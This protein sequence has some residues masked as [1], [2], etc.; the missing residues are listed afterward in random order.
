MTKKIVILT[1][2]MP[3]C[4]LCSG[5]RTI[6][7]DLPGN[8]PCDDIQF[9]PASP[10]PEFAS[11]L[12]GVKYLVLQQKP[13]IN[14]HVPVFE[15][16]VEYLK[17][18][19]FTS[20]QYLDENHKPPDHYC[21]EALVSLGFDYQIGVAFS[22]ITMSWVS[23]CS[24]YVW[25]FSSDKRVSDE[26]GSDPKYGFGVLFREMYGFMKPNFDSRYTL[27]LPK[28]QTCWTEEKFRS[29]VQRTGC[30]KIEGIYENSIGTAVEAKY[31]V[32]IRNIHGTYYVVYL[33]GAN[34]YGD[35]SEGEIKGTLESTATPYFYK[36]KW[37]M[38]N[39]AENPNEYISFDGGIMK[40]ITEKDKLLYIK[41]FPSAGDNGN[42]PSTAAA[43]SGSGFAI[44]SNGYIATNCHV[45]NGSTSIRVRGV[46]GDFTRAYR[47]RVIMEDQKNDLSIIKIDDPRFA[48]FG[49]IPYIISGKSS[50]V[51]SA[52]FCLGYPLR[53]TMGDEV[54]LT[55]GIISSRTGFRGDITAYQISAPVQPGNSGGPLFDERGN[56]V[57]II[58]AKHI[59]AE[60]VTYAIKSSYLL[61]LID[62]LPQGP[63][64]SAISIVN[65][66]LLPEQVKIVKKF[67]YIIEVNE[68]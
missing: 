68:E 13:S 38:S 17:A 2:L 7:P 5:Q 11:F 14:G 35:W 16:L 47:A 54:K 44:A 24:G 19:G 10:K 8:A 53:A 31:R 23:P 9:I 15:A 58:N 37:L 61:S 1:L 62:D 50:E 59:D 63:K 49:T 4:F 56:L 3:I 20:I 34:N 22:N 27:S 55:N 36:C 12:A 29:F 39:K 21:E 42:S 46:N 52:I 6:R 65:G 32:A 33:S 66:K 64:L 18:V 51:G 43:A 30:D 45:T 48:S 67:T 57:G 28:M 60:N 41:L 26:M 25:N 40:L